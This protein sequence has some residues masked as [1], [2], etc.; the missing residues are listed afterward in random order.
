[1]SVDLVGTS[2]RN[3]IPTHG[4]FNFSEFNTQVRNAQSNSDA[5]GYS[6]QD[7][8]H[9]MYNGRNPLNEPKSTTISGKQFGINQDF[10]WREDKLRPSLPVFPQSNTVELTASSQAKFSGSD[11]THLQRSIRHGFGQNDPALQH[12]LSEQEIAPA[13]RA[14]FWTQ[15]DNYLHSDVGVPSVVSQNLIET[16]TFNTFPNKMKQV[17]RGKHEHHNLSHAQRPEMT[18][19]SH[20]AS[21]THYRSGNPTHPVI[22]GTRGP[23][24]RPVLYSDFPLPEQPTVRPQE[25]PGTLEPTSNRAVFL[26]A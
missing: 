10:G 8:Q 20:T 17:V 1:M 16:G 4:G 11:R 13:I 12:L 9:K 21:G 23:L 24:E 6:G 18:N 3:A 19:Y 25:G 22:G 26:F 2:G 15:S 7:Y 5:T 14:G